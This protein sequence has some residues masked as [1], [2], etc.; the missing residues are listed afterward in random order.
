MNNK[1]LKET[2]ELR[3][4]EQ[5]YGQPNPAITTEDVI[6]AWSTIVGELEN[7]IEEDN[8]ALIE[9]YGEMKNNLAD[10]RL[11][12]QLTRLLKSV[13][14]NKMELVNILGNIRKR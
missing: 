14:G 2:F 8:P 4:V 3:P 1:L 6:A 9:I 11:Q 10:L 13:G 12:V 7:V 5:E